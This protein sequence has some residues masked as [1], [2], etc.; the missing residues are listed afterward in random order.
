MRP[1]SFAAA[2]AGVA[3]CVAVHAADGIALADLMALLRRDAPSSA[4][5]NETKQMALLDRPLESS[6]ELLFTPPARLEKRTTSPGSERLVVDGDRLVIER[7][8]RTQTMS[9]AQ[10]PQVATILEGVRATLAGDGATLARLYRVGLEGG[11]DS[12]RVSLVP[13]D[14]EVAKV[15]SRIVLAGVRGD[16][17]RV[18]IEQ[19]DGD[20]SFMQIT[21]AR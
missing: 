6:G 13:R 12:W 4:R 8:G 11:A 14:A 18:E 3:F 16:V 10:L 20:R 1:A 19:A 15:V 17:R 5:F 9:L 21:P 7:M 2:L